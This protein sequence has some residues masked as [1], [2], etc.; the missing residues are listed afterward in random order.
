[1][2]TAYINATIYTG[3][4]KILGKTLIVDDGEI[5]DITDKKLI[6]EPAKIIDCLNCVIAPGFIDL[7]IYGG[8]GFLFSNQPS[9]VAL[10]S[11]TNG[12]LHTG[13]TGFYST[14]ATNSMEIFHEAIKVVKE[15]PHP[16]VL[17]LHFEGPYINPVK[18][19]CSSE[20]IYKTPF[21]KRSE[22]IIER[23]EWCFENN[24]TGS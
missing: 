7:Q 1:M 9:A 8:G 19:R 16:A 14:L 18:T 12:L 2:L 21:D 22:K 6:P 5:K 17:G 11:M 13:T 4:K 10:Q 23:R 3:N 24:D 15:N 20:T